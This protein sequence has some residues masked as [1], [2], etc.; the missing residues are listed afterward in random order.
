MKTV[1]EIKVMLNEVKGTVEDFKELSQNQKLTKQTLETF[2]LRYS[3][4]IRVLKNFDV[5]V[6]LNPEKGY[7]QPLIVTLNNLLKSKLP[8]LANAFNLEEHTEQKGV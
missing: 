8:I 1:E 7:S 2:V 6:E 5:E 3:A 4:H